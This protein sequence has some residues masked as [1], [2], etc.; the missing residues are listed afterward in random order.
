M[1]NLSELLISVNALSILV[2]QACIEVDL[3]PTPNLRNLIEKR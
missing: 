2:I 1:Q 3:N